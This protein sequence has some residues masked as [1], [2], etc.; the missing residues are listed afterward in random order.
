VIQN[1]PARR[2]RQARHGAG[3]A[4]GVEDVGE[5]SADAARARHHQLDGFD[6][7]G[8]GCGSAQAGKRGE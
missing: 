8:R 5:F 3:A 4:A 7:Q 6:A 1:G 2:F